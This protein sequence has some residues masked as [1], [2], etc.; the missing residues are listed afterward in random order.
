MLH[1]DLVAAMLTHVEAV[2]DGRSMSLPPSE[3]TGL[4]TFSDLINPS[5]TG[6]CPFVGQAPAC[7]GLPGRPSRENFDTTI[8]R[9]ALRHLDVVRPAPIRHFLSTPQSSRPIALV[10]SKICLR[11]SF[12]PRW[13]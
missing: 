10:R 11:P 1:I 3:C 4:S 12:H 7:G 8:K 5:S 13:T 6:I 2:A 9:D